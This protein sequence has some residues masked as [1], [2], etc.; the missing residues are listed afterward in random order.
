MRPYLFGKHPA[1]RH[2]LY[3]PQGGSSVRLSRPSVRAAHRVA[4]P[5][6]LPY[7][8]SHPC[9]LVAKSNQRC[10]CQT[11]L[12]MLARGCSVRALQRSPTE[13]SRPLQPERL[14]TRAGRPPGQDRPQGPAGASLGPSRSL[15][16][17]LSMLELMLSASFS[18]SGTQV[19]PTGM[20]T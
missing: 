18:G 8:S 13:P 17:G 9:L 1:V 5:G 20:V 12:R 10:P 15:A 3:P 2:A 7:A 14:G 6:R 16:P 19:Q 4:V 11:S